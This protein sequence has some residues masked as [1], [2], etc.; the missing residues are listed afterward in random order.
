ME[1]TDATCAIEKSLESRAYAIT[2]KE[3]EMRI[4]DAIIEFLAKDKR[5]FV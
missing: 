4:A 1:E 5:G 3:N 2:T